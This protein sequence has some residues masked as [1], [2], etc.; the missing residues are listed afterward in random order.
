[1][2][3]R[4]R[5]VGFDLDGTIASYEG[6]KHIAH[7]G[8]PIEPMIR[9]IKILLEQGEEVK[10]FTARV[11]PNQHPADIL[12]ARDAIEKWCEEHI[13]RKLEVTCIK[14]YDMITLYD[15][16]CI[17]VVPNTGELISI[18][19][20]RRVKELEREIENLKNKGN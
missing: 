11:C 7:I 1:M 14:D 19:T 4:K 15:D 5:W 10:I 12:T 9:M 2:S 8:E 16:R 18:D 20:H 17:A 13:G 3:N 6:W